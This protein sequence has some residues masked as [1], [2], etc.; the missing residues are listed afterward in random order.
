TGLPSMLSPRILL[1]GI[2]LFSLN[3]LAPFVSAATPSAQ[4]S[5]DFNR[6]IRPILSAKCFDCHGP[7]AKQRKAELR[8]DTKSG[9]FA[10]LGGHFAFVPGK[11]QQSEAYRRL[12]STDP[13]E[14]MPPP[15]SGKT[16]TPAQ[17][18]SIRRWLDA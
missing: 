14:R 9:A 2:A 10:D 11:P 7:D 12:T 5:P 18:D 17:L 16:L 13:E 15:S 6:D 3:A 1:T 4:P 8:L